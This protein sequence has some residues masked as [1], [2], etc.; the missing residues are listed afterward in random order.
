MTN[1]KMNK[2]SG[3]WIVELQGGKVI[4]LK[5]LNNDG[6]PC[7]EGK[8]AVQSINAIAKVLLVVW[9]ILEVIF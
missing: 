4:W 8:S 9:K 3:R 7:D 1:N 2:D 5:R 6:I